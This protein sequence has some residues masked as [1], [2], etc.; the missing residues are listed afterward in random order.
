[1]FTPTPYFK[2]WPSAA[3]QVQQGDEMT[4]LLKAEHFSWP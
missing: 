4:M 2:L 1:M 3:V